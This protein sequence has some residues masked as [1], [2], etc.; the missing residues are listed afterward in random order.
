MLSGTV[1]ISSV[2]DEYKALSYIC[3]L[4]TVTSGV[5]NLSNSSTA[6]FTLALPT[7]NWGGH[8]IY[9]YLEY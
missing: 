5:L 8:Y 6:S 2:S 4:I 9:N 7:D 1:K 3:P